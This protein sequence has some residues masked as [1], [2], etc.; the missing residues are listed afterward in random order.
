MVGIVLVSHSHA[1]AQGA[2]E[3]ARQ[4]GGAD[5]RIEATGGLDEPGH[6]IGTDAVQ[7]AAAIERAWSPD[8]VLVLMDLGSA[9]LS[10]EMAMD[11]LPAD[12]RAGVLL[13]AAPIVEGAVAAAVAARSGAG[14]T[15]VAGEAAGGL[16]GKLAHLGRTPGGA[17]EPPTGAASAPTAAP[18]PGA[19]SVATVIRI[20]VTLPHGLHARPAARFVRA[21]AAEGTQV[22][23]RNA[24]TESEWVS[25]RSL[26][27]VATLGVLSGHDI[28]VRAVGDGADAVLRAI[29][30]LAARGFDEAPEA[31]APEPTRSASAPA[32]AIMGL[33]ASPGVATGPAV[34]FRV[35]RPDV[36]GAP[37][38]DPRGEAATL[39]AAI[40]ATRR[41]IEEQR[42]VVTRATGAGAAAIFSAH[43]LLLDDEALLGPARGAIA[44]GNPAAR[45]WFDAA[46]AVARDWERLDDPYQRARSADVRSVAA[47]VVAHA[48]GEPAPRPSLDRPGVLVAE[49][50]SPAEAA[51]LDPATALGVALA[52]GGP[53]S[54]AAVLTRSL[55]IPCTVGLGAA[56]MDVED[57]T[58][59]ALDGGEGYVVVSPDPEVLEGFARRG[60]EDRER[61]ARQRAAA[62]APGA[63]RDGTAIE[64]AANI[65][66]AAE[67]A[68]ALEAGCD[69]VGLFRTEV[70]FMG[71]D[72]MPTEDEQEREYRAAAEAL[73]GRRLVIR[74][75]DAGADKPVPYLRQEPEANPFLGLRGLRL[76]LARPDLLEPQLRAIL[77]AARG[78]RIGVMFPMVATAAEVRDARAALERARASLGDAAGTVEV[79][80]MVE[81]PAAALAATRL[82]P[83]VDFFSIGTNDL[84]QYVFAAER[85]N[86]RVASVADPLHPAVLELI[87]RTA[88]AASASAAWV[89][90]C[91]E[92]AADALAAPLLAGLGVTELS[93]G[94][95]AIPAVK[96]RLREVSIDEARALAA[97]CIAADDAD[98]VRALLRGEG[99]H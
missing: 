22:Q 86:P 59:L 72:A 20:S 84:T 33:P 73:G 4:M 89:G 53:T 95:P 8:G 87:A 25:A 44:A 5:A 2:A 91:G 83:H 92:L 99:A 58:T 26:N 85:G 71:R 35:P 23:V 30:D 19:A 24:T 46:E 16:A 81:V 27:A 6:P 75:L 74:T 52:S 51:A 54:H 31:P 41:D 50:L 7:V 56:L 57:G 78:T 37:R 93:M 36:S 77:R 79:G 67:V 47:Q 17:P 76:G 66:T 43:L 32:G 98:E 96:A 14:L 82:A 15:E 9:V 64:V 88:S 55:G 11:L 62:G 10:A 45:A 97:R 60:A 38:S 39:D 70:L 63:M 42:D 3:L 49:D 40:A 69:G 18:I 34:R 12:R 94:A 80:V 65:G 61:D 29:A 90:V 21:A 28:E 13:V 68:A 1:I 48:L